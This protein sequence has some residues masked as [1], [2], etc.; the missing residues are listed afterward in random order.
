MAG[1]KRYEYGER[2]L[3]E[4]IARCFEALEYDLTRRCGGKS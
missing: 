2:E 1:E 4:R 3:E